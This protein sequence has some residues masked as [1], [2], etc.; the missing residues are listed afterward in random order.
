MKKFILAFAVLVGVIVSVILY[1]NYNKS[2]VS[3]TN[4]VVID[5]KTGYSYI[6]LSPDINNVTECVKY[7]K[8]SYTQSSWSWFAFQFEID[9]KLNKFKQI[10]LVDRPA[11]KPDVFNSEIADIQNIN[12]I[13]TNIVTFD[14][15]SNQFGKMECLYF[16]KP[17][18]KIRLLIKM[19][20]GSNQLLLLRDGDQIEHEKNIR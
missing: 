12:Q 16:V 15:I 13:D 19:N 1:F 11:A 17:V 3:L 2:K 8:L 20:D 9:F 7:T 14:V 5:A 10:Y 6:D 18:N 4:K